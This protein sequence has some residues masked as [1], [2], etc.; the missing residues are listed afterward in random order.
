MKKH[1][2]FDGLSIEVNIDRIQN[3]FKADD[4]FD[5]SL[6]INPKRDFLF[7]S[8]VLGKYIAKNPKYITEVSKALALNLKDEPTIFIGFAETATGLGH[9]VFSNFSNSEYI[10]TTRENRYCS[11]LEFKEEHSHATDH[12]IFLKD[13][14]FFKNNKNICLV[15]DELTTG[16]TML[17]LIRQL[18]LHHPRRKY[19]VLTILDWRSREDQLKV[20]KME[21]ELGINIRVVSMLKGT[22]KCVGSRGVYENTI[23][24]REDVISEV[25]V[26]E[27]SHHDV[28]QLTGRYGIS[29]SQNAI[30]DYVAKQVSKEFSQD[31]TRKLVLGSGEFNYIPLKIAE[32]M[33]GDTYYQSTG[34][35]PILPIANSGTENKFEINNIYEGFLEYLYNIPKDFYKSLYIIYEYKPSNYSHVEYTKT[36]NSLKKLGI[37]KINIIF[38]GGNNDA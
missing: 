21:S 28:S 11:S 15:D 19:T 4:L 34:R 10:H 18:H 3:G 27:F 16:N 36:V 12:R 25:S 31:E 17:N 22:I 9:N 24:N 7:V 14:N 32:N 5:M 33:N 30:I 37:P 2:K 26:K 38:L 1:Y 13:E 35:S 6:R 8:K 23:S 29:S 20:S